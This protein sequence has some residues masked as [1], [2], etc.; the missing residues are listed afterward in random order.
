MVPIC[1]LST[2]SNS[3]RFV[4]LWMITVCSLGFES[5]DNLKTKLAAMT[6]WGGLN[7]CSSRSQVPEGREFPVTSISC[8]GDILMVVTS[9]TSCL[10]DTLW[11][12]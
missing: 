12:N 6:G 4:P 2:S 7:G 8:P 1:H 9:Q 5:I 10:M 11:S 3:P